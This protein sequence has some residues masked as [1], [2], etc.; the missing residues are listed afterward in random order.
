MA[1]KCSKIYAAHQSLMIMKEWMLCLSFLLS[2][3]IIP[4]LFIHSNS[5]NF[6]ETKFALL[7][8][9]KYGKLPQNTET[10]VI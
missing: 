10:G 4:I 7:Y 1:Q 2:S 3:L 8:Y 5:E 9:E 6:R